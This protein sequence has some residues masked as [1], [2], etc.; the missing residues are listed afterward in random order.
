ML[1]S[2]VSD[3]RLALRML[4]KSRRFTLAV[5]V[6]LAIGIASNTLIF[7]V[8]ES[9]F[10]RSMPYPDASRLMYVSQA[11]PGFPEGGG[12]FAYPY[13]RDIA[14]QNRSFDSLAGYQVTG[15]LAITD[16]A[17]PVRIAVTY[18]TPNYFTLLGVR[19]ALGRVFQE[20][21]DRFGSGDPVVVLSYPFW[22]RQFSGAPDIIGRTIHL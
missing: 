12:Q 19:M 10:W 22:Q 8:A 2:L 11:Y 7:A 5:I 4:L 20:Q 6:T 16:S 13:Y 1:Q 9:V 17:Q 18:C 15:P 21:E 14:E 3:L